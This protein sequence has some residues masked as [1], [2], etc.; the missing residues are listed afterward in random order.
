MEPDFSGA[1]SRQGIRP[2]TKAGWTAAIVMIAAVTVLFVLDHPSSSRDRTIY[3][4]WASVWIGSGALVLLRAGSTRM[5]VLVGC[6]LLANGVA[7]P[8]VDVTESTSQ[9]VLGRILL[10]V[11]LSL[12]VLTLSVF[13]DGRF[14]PSW[15]KVLCVGFA[16]WQ[17]VTV[18]GTKGTAGSV[19]DVIGGIAFFAGLCI[20]IVAQVRRYRHEQ[21]PTQRARTKWV[22][23]GVCTSLAVDLGVS[24]PYF[25][26]GWFP[27]LVAPGSAYDDFQG[28]VGTLAVL[29]IPICITI[30]MLV[31]N[32]FD[33]DVVISRTLVYATLWTTVAIGYLGVS[34]L[35][36]IIVGR[37][38]TRVAPLVAATVVAV[39]FVP[40]RSWLQIRVRRLVYGLR[41]EPYA[42][43]SDL[44]RQLADSPRDDDLPDRLVS[45]I[46]RSLRAP[47]V[48]VAV[49]DETGFPV[50]AESGVPTLHR[51]DIP[52]LHRGEQV[53]MLSVGYDDR[54][55][56]S[57]A[58]RSLLEDLSRQAGEAIHGLQLTASLRSGAA[59]LQLVR[60][61]LV[62]A[63]EEARRRLRRD[64]HDGLAPTLAAAGLIAATAADL[65]VRDPQ[66]SGRLLGELQGTLRGAVGDIRAM[67]DDLGPPA[68]DELGLVQ[69]LRARSSDL[70]Q[71]VAVDVSGPDHLPPLPA[72]VEVAAFRICQEAFMNVI[73]HSGARHV[74]VTIGVD[75]GLSLVVEDDGVGLGNRGPAGVGLASMRERAAE[76]GGRC[77][78]EDRTAGGT[79][80]SAWFPLHVAPGDG[81]R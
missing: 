45:T 33:V 53:G 57:S 62:L 54:H 5:T 55:R 13:P 41:A 30:A 21:D 79:T 65:S 48:A 9:A 28:A 69:A 10:G 18:V 24:L 16:L 35:V 47:Y 11:A 59:Q 67:V 49:G 34:A 63:R 39:L 6:M 36:G 1:V 52:L 7:T 58:D 32:L 78:I 50:A 73:K 17:V 14:A 37:Q 68:L 71:V 27:N 22:V 29:V 40:L 77:T 23:Y 81:A 15:L 74:L 61:Q 46:R 38:D 70:A 72:A 80:V 12:S 75:K 2:L 60:E 3:L 20:P 42:A 19:L 31:G 56:L 8:I 43:L 25:A 44:G 66:R 76:L 64:L 26:P 51:F 4:V